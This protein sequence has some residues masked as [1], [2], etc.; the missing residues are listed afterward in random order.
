MSDASI[1]NLLN[2][3]AFR[4]FHEVAQAGS[5]RK[6]GENLRIAPSAV[7]RQIFLLEAKLGTQLFERHRG[8]GGVKLTAAGEVLKLR[9]GQAVVELSKAMEEIQALSDVQRGRVSIAVNDTLASDLLYRLIASHHQDAPRLDFD[10]HIGET[11]DLAEIML[12][13]DVDATLCFGMAPRIGIRKIWEKECETTI[14]VHRDHPLARKKSATLGECAQYPLAMQKGGEWT[15]GLVDAMFREAGLRPR[16]LLATNSFH[17]MREIVSSGVAISI[18]TRLPG[19]PEAENLDLA[20][21]RLKAPLEHF[22]VLSC[23]VPMDRRLP[24]AS[25]AFI[26]RLVRF[27]EARTNPAA[28]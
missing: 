22:S 16:I 1:R 9:I 3:P 11:P 19:V 21:V 27:L 17:L 20:H 14:L 23:C 24:A 4:Y 10:V 25:F 18:Q 5:F 8:R 7:H 28:P 12:R 26:E 2:A 13:G 15:R 6:A